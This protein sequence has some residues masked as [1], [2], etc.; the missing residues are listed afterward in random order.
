MAKDLQH[1]V[2]GRRP[3]LD[4]AHAAVVA[5][6]DRQLQRLIL[7]PEQYLSG[8]SELLEFVEQKPD[9]AA[10]ALVR[11][12]LDLADL[13]PAIAR[14]QD[15]PQLAAQRLRIPCR[16]AALTKEAQLVFG[17]RPLQPQQ[18][19]VIDQAGIV[20]AVRIDHQ[21]ADQ[22]A[23]INQVMPV[24]PVPGQARGLEAEHG[25]SKARA[26]SSHQF[27]EAGALDQSGTGASQIV[28]DH[29]DRSEAER[30]R[31]L[32]KRVLPPLAFG[33]FHDLANGRLADIDHRAAAE[34]LRGDLGVH[35]I[36]PA[37]S[38]A[39][40]FDCRGLRAAGPPAR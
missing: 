39:R 29:R 32:G 11:I 21:R 18:Q 16:N 31:R 10:D 9:D 30:A 8:A 12:D 33:M 24:A 4:F 35:H 13:V 34:V 14:R 15:E 40:F 25:A 20:R 17:H 27:L 6:G 3:P 36:P 22:G 38:A 7:G 5:S 26:D 23:Q 37:R 2:V 19:P 28:V 1:R